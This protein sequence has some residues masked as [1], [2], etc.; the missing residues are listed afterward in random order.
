MPAAHVAPS[1]GL[2]RDVERPPVGRP[3]LLVVP[4]ED[5]S[6]RLEWRQRHARAPRAVPPPGAGPDRNRWAASVATSLEAF[7]EAPLVLAHGF[8][9]L[10]TLRATSLFE[11]CVA[12]AV[13]VAPADPD[14]YGVLARLPATPLPYPTLLVASRDDPGIKLTKAGALATRWGSQFVVARSGADRAADEARLLRAFG[15]SLGSRAPVDAH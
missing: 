15:A 13:L 2:A 11:R 6:E 7:R 4:G 10:A 12:G 1:R 14:D 3:P 5:R 8:G 9:V